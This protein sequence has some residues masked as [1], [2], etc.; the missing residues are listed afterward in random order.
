MEIFQKLNICSPGC[1]MK[2]DQMRYF[3]VHT[4]L[5][6]I[7]I[8]YQVPVYYNNCIV[9]TIN[10]QSKQFYANSLVVVDYKG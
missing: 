7:I 6:I 8:F 10:C 2:M 5:E 9:I 1:M 3:A 4:L